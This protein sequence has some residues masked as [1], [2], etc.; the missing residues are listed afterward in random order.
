MK[1]IFTIL[2][3]LELI[4]CLF[5]GLNKVS[6]K[7]N[8]KGYSPE[9]DKA[10]K[11]LLKK[12]ASSQPEK[13]GNGNPVKAID[14]V[15]KVKF[16]NEL[17]RDIVKMLEILEVQYP[18][19]YRKLPADT[20]IKILRSVGK[21]FNAGIRIVEKK[22]KADKKAVP[23]GAEKS[24]IKP[25]VTISRNRLSYFRIDDFSAAELKTLTK[26]CQEISRLKNAPVGAILDLRD[27]EGG[28]WLAAV[29]AL[30]LFCSPEKK[31]IKELNP[32]CKQFI[33]VPCAVLIGKNT[34]GAGEIFAFLMAKARQGLLI[35]APTTGEPFPLKRVEMNSKYD[36]LIPQIPE[37]LGMIP[38]SPVQPAI[39]IKAYPQISYTDLKKV[40]EER[41]DNC[42]SRAVDLLISY[43]S[44]EHK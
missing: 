24:E 19:M 5:A 6:D 12:T 28:E 13:S 33:K 44:I 11:E 23:K 16:N 3:I 17:E 20:R 42:L 38:A 43:S 15:F 32:E 36:L 25:A 8:A 37:E 40:D 26:E 14:K 39:K 18:A 34:S 1:R 41:I 35:G 27:C 30:G 21:G 7:L 29:N 2:L 10:A 9:I 22:P 31:L 4:P